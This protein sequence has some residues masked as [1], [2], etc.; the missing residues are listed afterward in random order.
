MIEKSCAAPHCGAKRVVVEGKTF[1]SSTKVN[2]VLNIVATR[3]K[4]RVTPS[5]Q[6]RERQN[7]Q[8]KICGYLAAGESVGENDPRFPRSR[9]PCDL[10]KAIRHLNRVHK[11]CT[12]L[13]IK[14]GIWF[15]VPILD[16]GDVITYGMEDETDEIN[17]CQR[18]RK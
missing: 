5:K 11:E 13:V 17:K 16:S 12:R 4:K 10:L 15:L 8:R 14:D 6:F 7:L 18:A 3:H 1:P 9:F 2:S